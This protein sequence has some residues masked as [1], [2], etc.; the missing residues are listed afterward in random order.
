MIYI[1]IYIFNLQVSGI[2]IGFFASNFLLTTVAYLSP[3]LPLWMWYIDIAL[4]G[5]AVSISASST[6][7]VIAVLS[8]RGKAIKLV[9]IFFLNRWLNCNLLISF[10]F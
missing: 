9:C 2:G 7:G 5:I 10:C 6:V 8:K 4:Y 3:W 1:Y